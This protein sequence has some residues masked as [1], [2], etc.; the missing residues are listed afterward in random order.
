MSRTLSI[1][2]KDLEAIAR[3][4]DAIATDDTINVVNAGQ[5]LIAAHPELESK[6]S[7]AEWWKN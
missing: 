7:H 3:L 2:K 1:S 5:K 4:L 6:M